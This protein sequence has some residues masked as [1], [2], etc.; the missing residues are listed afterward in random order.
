MSVHRPSRLSAFHG[1]SRVTKNLSIAVTSAKRQGKP[2]AHLLLA[3]PAGLGKTTLAMSVIPTEMEAGVHFVNCAAVDKPTALTSVLSIV[4]EGDVLFLDEVHALP[5]AAREHLLTAME[6]RK[7]SVRIG[8]PG[9]E[10]VIDVALPA[11]TI[12]A[13]TTRRGLLDGPLRSRFQHVFTLEP[14]TTEEMEQII[15]WHVSMK[16]V[17]IDEKG[18]HILA[19]AAKGV[20]RNAVNLLSNTIDTFVAQEPSDTQQ[21]AITVGHASKTLSRLGFKAELSPEEYQYMSYLGM[22]DRPVGVK[23]LA[24]ALNEQ[25]VTVEEVYEPWLLRS[26]YVHRGSAGRELTEAGKERWGQLKQLYDK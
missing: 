26:G 2:L 14:Y 4:P 16:G 10:S 19:D 7:L 13:A 21:I 1:Q 9:N 6:D 8:D 22:V 23:A 12:I 5:A 11:F 18:C 25:P 17:T 24:H 20:A 3:G 15:Y